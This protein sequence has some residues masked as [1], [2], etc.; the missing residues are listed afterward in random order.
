MIHLIYYNDEVKKEYLNFLA[1]TIKGTQSSKEYKIKRTEKLFKDLLIYEKIYNLD[2]G[3]FDIE[4][5]KISLNDILFS[6]QINIST[7]KQRISV[8]YEYLSWYCSN[9][10]KNIKLISKGKLDVEEIFTK[11]II[12][13]AFYK[14]VDDFLNSLLILFNQ[15]G[16]VDILSTQLKKIVYFTDMLLLY[17]GVPFSKLKDLRVE[18]LD[19]ENKLIHLNGE[20]IIKMYWLFVPYY[21]YVCEHRSYRN[22]KSIWLEKVK[23]VDYVISVP[24]ETLE[25]SQKNSLKYLSKYVNNKNIL[26]TMNKRFINKESI[27]LSGLLFKM[28]QTEQKLEVLTDETKQSLIDSFEVCD[29]VKNI[30]MQYELYKD[31][32]FAN[33][34][35]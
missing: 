10:N 1:T 12:K 18:Q 3:E 15:G 7:A 11:N 27:V 5:F 9:I 26:K 32:Y 21:K 25:Q 8:L 35:C 33:Q 13:Q 23:D 34:I 30:S 28:Y 19:F 24:N 6:R 2:V 16:K 20:R 17:N 22:N 4:K 31:V 29:S 14:D